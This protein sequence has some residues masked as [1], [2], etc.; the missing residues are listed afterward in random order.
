MEWSAMHSVDLLTELMG[1][2]AD[3]GGAQMKIVKG[4]DRIKEIEGKIGAPDAEELANDLTLAIEE[5]ARAE[6]ALIE[7]VGKLDGVVEGRES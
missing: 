1:A 4:Q 3:L 6:A 5:I 2:N 7:L